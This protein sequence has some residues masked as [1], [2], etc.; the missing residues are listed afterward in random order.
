[1][2]C[3]DNVTITTTQVAVTTSIAQVLPIRSD[4]RSLTIQ[5]TGTG[6]VTISSKPNA[7]V[8]AGLVLKAASGALGGDGGI[9]T[10]VDYVPNNALYAIG[11][12]AS[13][14]TIMEG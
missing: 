7:A 1:M 8:G 11:A 12:A 6:A 13:T 9:I 4:R 14:L 3:L 2:S 10:F 5:N